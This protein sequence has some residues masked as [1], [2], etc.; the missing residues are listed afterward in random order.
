M[1][2]TVELPLWLFVLILLFAAITFASHFL[3]PSVRWFFRRRLER[4][5]ARLN[6]RLERPIQPFKL[7]RRYDMI[8]RLI[9]DPQVAQAIADHARGKGI[10][11]N[12]AFEEARR[13]AREIV[14]SFS[15]VAYFSVAI[16]LARFLSNA[17]YRV[18]LGHVDE[19]ALKAI[20][21]EATVVFVMNH[22]S[23]MDYVLITYLAANRSALSYAVGEWA[24]VWPLSRLI[25]A[26]G[27]YFIR[28]KSRN[29]LYRRVLA[30]Y[31]RLATQGGVT[32]AMFPE[33]GLSLDG[34]LAEPKVGLLKYIVDGQLAQGDGGRDVV[35]VPVALNYDRVLEDKILTS[36]AQS[37]ERRFRPR[38][39]VVA[40]RMLRQLMLWLT[41][42]YQRFGYAAVSFGR[43]LSLRVFM[44]R[45][46]EEDA[47]TVLAQELMGRIGECVPVLPVALVAATLVRLQSGSNPWSRSDIEQAMEGLLAQIPFAHIHTP[48]DSLGDA[49]EVGLRQ[50]T[51]R[52]I[53]QE[54]QNRYQVDAERG[55]L[56]IYYA[57]SIRHLIPEPTEATSA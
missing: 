39:H 57:N 43:P 5:V 32:Q 45:E 35:F 30:T 15:A 6:R 20:D 55:D 54:H 34:A 23:N 11:E 21:P 50:L 44:L 47:P 9:Y 27:A 51:A 17:V 28:R 19:A 2:Q 18:R 33:G 26:M 42:R 41:G 10:P 37:G 40:I 36:A 12:V 46:G 7:A 1:T 52:G 3:F 31:V 53:L 14:P 13:Y 48:R 49:A 22:R 56:L 4:A 25:R 8:Q 24:R 16:R 38:I 29:D